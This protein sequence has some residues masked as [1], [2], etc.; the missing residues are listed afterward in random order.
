MALGVSCAQEG[1]FRQ[2]YKKVGTVA[3]VG[4]LTG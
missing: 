3:E 4:A 2:I 1:A